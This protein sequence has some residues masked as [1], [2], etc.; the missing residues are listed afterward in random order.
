MPA[1]ITH[2]LHAC[3]ACAAL[4]EYDKYADAVALGALGP[5]FLYYYRLI[6]SGADVRELGVRLHSVDSDRLF[7][8][9]ADYL[10]SHPDDIRALYF[11]YGF[12]CHFALDAT[13]HPYVYFV[14]NHIVKAENYHKKPFFKHVLIEHSIDIIMLRYKKEQSV[15]K[16]GLKNCVPLK[17]EETV[18][19]AVSVM[20]Y[21]VNRLMPNCGF[22]DKKCKKAYY[23]CRRYL[24]LATDRTGI[25]RVAIKVLETLCFMRGTVSNFLHPFMEDGDWDYSNYEK[26]DWTDSAGNTR[27]DS[28][29]ELYDSACNLARSLCG[30][31]AQYVD[32]GH[33]D[34]D[35]TGN[36]NMKGD[37]AHE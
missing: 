34:V 30:K 23:D 5:D 24:R 25:K 32:S 8:A 4:P 12:I 19:S 7:S 2:Y 35:F 11:T 15:G 16:F 20:T 21:V 14:Q 37:K 10:A 22:T 1:Q 27:D 36:F 31:L 9:F 18:R 3:D 33:T 13:A 28:F 17:D 6:G 26:S 29:F